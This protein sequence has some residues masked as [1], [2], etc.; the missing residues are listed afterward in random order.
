MATKPPPTSLN[1]GV[2]L[3]AFDVHLKGI[4]LD[5]TLPAHFFH[6]YQRETS[7]WAEVVPA[8]PRWLSQAAV[9]ITSPG[10]L[11]PFPAVLG[12]L[13]GKQKGGSLS[14]SAEVV[15][16]RVPIES[17]PAKGLKE[18]TFALLDSPITGDLVSEQRPKTVTFPCGQFEVKVTEPTKTHLGVADA[19]G[20]S[21]HRLSNSAT[22]TERSGQLFS[23]DVARIALDTLHTALSFA[24]G[25]WVGMTLVEA[26]GASTHPTWFRWGTTRMSGASREPSWY[27]PRHAEWLQPLCDALLQ[28]KSNEETWEP[29]QTALYWYV[30]SNTRGAGIDSS[31]ILS[32]CALELLSWFVIVKRTGALSEEGYGQLSSA[33]EKLRLALT[34]LGIPRQIPT[35]LKEVVALRKE[36]KDV[37][38][39]VVQARN[40]LVHPTQSR[41][42]KRRAKR[43]YPWYE[44]WIAGQWLLELVIL[45]LLGYSGSYRNRT[46]WREFDPIE[47]V[48][49]A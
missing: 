29:V 8:T 36:W 10:H 15:P 7:V 40:Y 41:S 9:E 23:S 27:D 33:S 48:P 47:R 11:E 12:G 44:L 35:A 38:D 45:R 25:R 18:V 46:R 6:N 39:A 30:R 16:L 42:G 13:S 37:A 4:H 43:E 31:L 34:L 26:T 24:A 2:L 5:C 49:W 21:P 17:V 3:G 22:I 28:L 14:F 32:Q 20:S 1:D 19:L